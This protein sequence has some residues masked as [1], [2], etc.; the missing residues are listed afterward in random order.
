M[1]VVQ[2]GVI[3][4]G[5]MLAS[6]AAMAQSGTG[7]QTPSNDTQPSFNDTTNLTGQSNTV[8][9]SGHGSS[10]A[11]TRTGPPKVGAGSSSTGSS[12][13]SSGTSREPRH[14]GTTR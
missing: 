1:R 6:G 10:S 14:N 7:S 8:A 4:A 5:L 9:P 2:I 3:A 11:A 13:G 12:T